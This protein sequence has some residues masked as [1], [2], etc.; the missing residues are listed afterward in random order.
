MFRDRFNDKAAD[1]FTDVVPG[2]I[3]AVL[4][5]CFEVRF[6]GKVTEP[7][8]EVSLPCCFRFHHIVP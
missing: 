3:N 4:D 5:L 7:N 2:M 1:R 6:P 8:V